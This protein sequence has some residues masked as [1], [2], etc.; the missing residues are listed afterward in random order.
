MNGTLSPLTIR[1]NG[2]V[3]ASK[4]QVGSVAA[5]DLSFKW[6]TEKDTLHL[7]EASV[8]IFGGKISGQFDVP[9]RSELSG[10]GSAKIEDI[11]L[12]AIGKS[13]LGGTKI[14]LEG[15]ASGTLK[16]ETPAATTG[17]Q[18]TT[19]EVDL[20]APNLKFQG[21]AAKNLKG[22]GAFAQGV[23]K[24][25]L[26]AGALDGQVEVKPYPQRPRQ[27]RTGGLDLGSLG[28]SVQMAGLGTCS[29]CGPSCRRW[30]AR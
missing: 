22:T 20:A 28:E 16:I 2:K 25:T 17:R 14:K 6:E 7:G 9:L 29:G 5:Q 26:T 21:I 15:K 19:A 1:G 11:D 24:Y 27:D 3:Q 30:T 8:A 4:L 12:G 18:R 23:L 13:L 10:S